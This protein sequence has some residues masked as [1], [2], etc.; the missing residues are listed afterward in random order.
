VNWNSFI[1]LLLRDQLFRLV[2][3]GTF[4]GRACLAS[5]QDFP[6]N[7]EPFLSVWVDA[8][9]QTAFSQLQNDKFVKAD[10]SSLNYGYTQSVIWLRLELTNATLESQVRLF[11]IELNTI[12]L[13]DF[14]QE[15]VERP[16]QSGGQ[17]RPWNPKQQHRHPVL[18]MTLPPQSQ[19]TFYVRLE[20]NY[21]LGLITWIHDYQ[22][23]ASKESREAIIFGVYA[24]LILFALMLALFMYL[25]TAHP[26]F[27]VY[28]FIL[29]SYHLGYQFTNFGLTWIHLWPQATWWADRATFFFIE[30]AN[31]AAIVFIRQTLELKKNLPRVN[32]CLYI[33]LAKSLVFIIWSWFELDSQ[34]I[35]ITVLST[36]LLMLIY[37]SIG[38]YLWQKGSSAGKYLAIA[39]LPILLFNILAIIQALALLSFESS[40][41][42]SAIR[43]DLVLLGC[44][45]QAVFLAIAVGD[46]FQQMQK[47]RIDEQTARRK[48]EK[49]L[50]DAHALQLAFIRENVQSHRFEIITSH[51]PSAKIGGDWLGYHCDTSNQRLLLAIADVTGHGLPAALLTGAIHG[52]F[53]GL[54]GTKEMACLQGPELLAMLMDRMN[55]VVCMTAMN[56]SLLATMAILTVDLTSGRIDYINAGHTPIVMIRPQGPEYFLQGGSPLGLP[57]QPNF[58]VGHYQ[59]D[60]GDTLFL[61]TDGLM[62][63]SISPRRLQLHHVS[64]MLKHK[65]PLPILHQRLEALAGP[66]RAV[67]ED[68][69]SYIIC[70][71][72]SA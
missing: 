2:L 13:F 30:L 31:I 15:G 42:R 64:R 24:G 48:L 4:C 44:A 6:Q 60:P 37:Y 61:Y 69:Y 66:G 43:F 40:W 12:S 67:L 57:E 41:F 26:T 54:A 28:A 21:S 50:D 55:E 53:Y 35:S 29:I 70:R 38:I 19:S 56:T 59:G 36:G 5:A 58:G 51:H 3:F 16:I 1:L 8:Q 45:I 68:D 23:L 20:N 65:D 72:M 71:L 62:D 46:Q 32:L 18:Q 52:A 11:E 39:W 10:S 63:N 49:N 33:P 22:S 27:I 34:L 7:A 25:S 17:K 9:G 14:Y 47:D